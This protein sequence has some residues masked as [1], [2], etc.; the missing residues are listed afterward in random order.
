MPEHEPITGV[1]RQNKVILIY[2]LR[3]VF[4][5]LQKASLYEK[6]TASRTSDR[7]YELYGSAFKIKIKEE[8]LYERSIP[9]SWSSEKCI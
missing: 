5:V 7:R 3:S 1:L 6:K 8:T 4:F 2:R 9:D